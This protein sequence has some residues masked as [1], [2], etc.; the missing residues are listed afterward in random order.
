MSENDQPSLR[1]SVI[2]LFHKLSQIYH[3]YF[4]PSYGKLLPL[5]KEDSDRITIFVSYKKD[6][7]DIA[8]KITEM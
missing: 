2:F 4:R 8:I 1:A 3:T 7:E 5:S 6:D